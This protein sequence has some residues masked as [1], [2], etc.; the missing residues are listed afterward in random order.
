M[1]EDEGWTIGTSLA[2]L[3]FAVQ[4]VRMILIVIDN[5]DTINGKVIGLA[6]F[7]FFD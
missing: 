5:T 2:G 7:L 1:E 6:V 4:W 3:I